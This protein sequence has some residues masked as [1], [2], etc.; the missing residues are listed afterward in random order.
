MNQ[1]SVREKI[2]ARLNFKD[3]RRGFGQSFM[4]ILYN[5]RRI[6][7]E[8]TKDHKHVTGLTLETREF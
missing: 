4:R 2:I 8:R 3:L 5:M 1:L 6:N 7:K